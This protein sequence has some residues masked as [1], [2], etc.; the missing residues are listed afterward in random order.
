[1]R[2]LLT[3]LLA[4]SAA[5]AQNMGAIAPQF[6]TSIQN[7]PTVTTTTYVLDGASDKAG[8]ILRVGKTGNIH[9][10]CVSTG[11][12]TT[13]ANVDARLETVDA[14]TGLPT[15][16]LFGTN[17]NGTIAVGNNDDNIIVC[18]ILTADAAVTQGDMLACT[19]VNDAGSPGNMQLA[20]L[21]TAGQAV[22]DFPY[23]ATDASGGGTWAKITTPSALMCGLEY[24][25][26]SYAFTPGMPLMNNYVYTSFGSS[27]NPNHRAMR[28]QFPVATYVCGMG[29]AADSDGDFDSIL[30]ADNWD[31][32]NGAA[33]ARRS[34]D[35]DIRQSNI[36]KTRWLM[37]ESCVL[38]AANTTYRAIIKPTSATTLSLLSYSAQSNAQLGQ[39]GSTSW[40]ESVANNP[41]D[42]TDWTDTNTVRP[43]IFLQHYA[44]S[45]AGGG[46]AHACASVR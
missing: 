1:M 43:F 22:I 32:T 19:F 37:F 15:N 10:V 41:N 23:G 38:L 46:G 44:A 17:T 30:A 14:T 42:S 6:G 28:F 27:T 3:L 35:K 39:T 11:T 8:A 16:T 20:G 5:H 12:V 2:H 29:V 9:K 33:L 31:G 34:V 26:G 45:C 13:G 40:Y 25:D 18:N 21:G 7:A 4:T 36:H 24:D